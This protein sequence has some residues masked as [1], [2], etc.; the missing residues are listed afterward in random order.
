MNTTTISKE[1]RMPRADHSAQTA[2]Y[3][4][5]VAKGPKQPMVLETVDLGPVGDEDAE[6]AV[7]HCG[8][9]HSDLSILNNDWG[10]SQYPAVLGHEVIGRVTDA[11]PNA[12]GLKVGQRVGVGWNSGSC[13]HCQQCLSGS[14]HLCPEVQATIVGHRG[15]FASHIRAHWAWAIPLPEK[16]D[17]AEAGPLLCGGITV[18]APLL[19]FVKPTARVGIIGIGGLGHMAVKFAAA[20]GCDVTAFTSSE[21]KFDEAKG[22]GAN[23]VLTTKDSAAIKKLGGSFDLLISTVNV[24]LDWD[25]II[26]TLAPNGRLHVVG[27]VLQPLPISAFSL[28]AQQRSVS[29]S[30]T[31]SPV[32]I[33]TML[34][35]ASRHSIAPQTEH[36]PMSKINEAFARLDSGKARYRIV[37][38]ADF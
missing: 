17:F 37:L 27:V 7:E 8:L 18:F 30:P 5:W 13:M 6:I 29:G 34:D 22:F 15:G 3:Q 32:A 14:H 20:Y 1:N 16:L 31:G 9:C 35:F 24:P 12:K 19:M 11:G 26:G 21:N 28:I 33:E 25:A 23:H 10:I 38:D 36:Y 4:A 2:N